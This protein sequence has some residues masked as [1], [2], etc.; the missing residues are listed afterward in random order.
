MIGNA[1]AARFSAE[2]TNVAMTGR[3]LA[4]RHA[5]RAV[6]K[7]ME[8]AGGGSFFRSLGLERIF[9]DVRDG[10]NDTGSKLPVDAGGGDPLGCCPARKGY[11]RASGWGSLAAAAFTDAA[12][13]AKPAGAPSPPARSSSP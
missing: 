2:T 1:A 13:R 4:A 6:E 9:R 12:G 10:N 5:I 11:D 8:V 7:A 3:T